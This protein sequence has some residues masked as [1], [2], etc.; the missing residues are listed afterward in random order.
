MAYWVVRWFASG[1]VSIRTPADWGNL[2]LVLMAAVSCLITSLP[3]S[4]VPQ[5]LRLLSGMIFFYT[6]VNWSRSLKR[7]Y[8]LL[9]I[10]A[11]L[12]ILLS[13][14]ALVSVEWSPTKLQLVALQL[15]NMFPVA[16]SD[17]VHPNVMAGT[18]LLFAPIVCAM[19]VFNRW[20]SLANREKKF[21]FVLCWIALLAIT[22]I[23][24]L[25]ASRGAW[26]AFITV[27]ALLLSMRWKWGFLVFMALVGSAVLLPYFF[28]P[29]DLLG[30]A[31]ENQTLGSLQ[32]RSQV[33]SQALF[34]IEVF[35]VTGVGM[36]LFSEVAALVTPS[37]IVSPDV[38]E[39]AHNLFLQ[40][41]VDLGIPGLIAWLSVL[42][43]VFT[44]SWGL[45]RTGKRMNDPWAAGLGAG[46]FCS[47]AALVLH[48]F[49]DSVIWGIV[50]QAP[51]VWFLWGTTIALSLVYLPNKPIHAKTEDTVSGVDNGGVFDISSV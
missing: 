18:L 42:L 46:F 20:A 43:V 1:Q 21:A 12:G 23:I 29:Y 41:A 45:Y 36:G 3:G 17:T 27:M 22:P 24:L 11:L 49:M 13:L 26:I 39:H 35:P 10:L 30:T 4:T 51:V 2:L 37:V 5:V 32:A 48:G 19:V 50:R 44:V 47:S 33:M 40:V 6:I 7:S 34:I 25:T 28:A 8:L 14:F 15:R 38:A 16:V 31:L 9:S